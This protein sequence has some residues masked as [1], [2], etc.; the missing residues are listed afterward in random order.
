MTDK[1][2]QNK[3]LKQRNKNDLPVFDSDQ[4][5]LKLFTKKNKIKPDSQKTNFIEPQTKGGINKHGIKVIDTLSQN[6][7]FTETKENFVELLEESF[8]K[9]K[10]LYSFKNM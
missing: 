10:V 6:H 7:D 9:R 1:K 8:K 3:G 5:F 4:D 2:K